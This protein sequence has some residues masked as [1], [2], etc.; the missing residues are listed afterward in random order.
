MTHFIKP[1][2]FDLI[3]CM[4]TTLVPL[5][6]IR[7]CT[8]DNNE[9]CGGLIC[10]PDQRFG[11]W[12]IPSCVPSNPIPS[13]PVNTLPVPA[14]HHTSVGS[15]ASSPWHPYIVTDF[16]VYSF[17]LALSHQSM[18]ML[19][20]LACFEIYLVEPPSFPPLNQW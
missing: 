11:S 8:C 9:P 19:S 12:L 6:E 15:Y 10:G 14:R 1:I 13:H 17:G 3:V 4:L 20:Q 2:Y 18:K 5:A 7:D 16:P